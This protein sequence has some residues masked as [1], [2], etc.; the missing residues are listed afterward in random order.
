MASPSATS[1]T[2]RRQRSTRVT[3]A[4]VLV[5]LAALA[6]VGAVV[7]GSWLVVSLAAVLAV[8]LGAAATKITH[9]ELL[10][11]RVEAARDRAQQAQGY[12]AI[13]DARVADQ[14]RHDAYMTSEI[15]RR[16][17]T[18]ADL[19]AALAAAHQRAADAVR[20]RTEEARRADQAERDGQALAVR[21]EQAEQ[22]AAEAI[23]RVH[24]LETELDTVRAE[25]TAAQ[26]AQGWSSTR[27]A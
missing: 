26:T 18:I 10:A 24:E 15:S 12:R 17:E 16:T 11:A 25:L 23:V 9:S 1:V 27:T 6:V 7:S 3:V 8:A 20:A 19:E 13:T 22:R 2:R 14:A 4:V 21:L 5:A